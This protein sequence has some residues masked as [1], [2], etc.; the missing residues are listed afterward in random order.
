MS[1]PNVVAIAGFAL[2]TNLRSWGTRLGIIAG[3]A[4]VMLG[5]AVT[6][7]G[8]RGWTLDRDLGFYGCFVAA[9]FLLR[10][11]LE[12]QRATNLDTFLQRDLASPVQHSL[13][14]AVSLLAAWGLFCAGTFATL[15]LASAGDIGTAAWYTA[16]WGLR[17]LLL[18]GFVLWVEA[19]ATI[20]LPLLLPALIYFGLLLVLTLVLDEER[21]MA[22]FLAVDRSRPSGLLRLGAHALGGFVLS[23]GLFTLV[24][25]IGPGAS[26]RAIAGRVA[27]RSR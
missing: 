19:F 11:G 7:H 14:M 25:A 2:L 3:V 1:R 16:S 22:L 10:S 15:L 13:G 24:S 9:L 26:P 27:C 5:S 6:W 18:L 17:L 12:A 4:I 8:G 21:A 20:R 23:T